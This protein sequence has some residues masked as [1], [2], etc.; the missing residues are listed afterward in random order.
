MVAPADAAAQTKPVTVTITQIEQIGDDFDFTSLGDF[1]AHVTID[2]TTLSTFD[3]R[4][5]FDS[6]FIVPSGPLIPNPAWVLTKQVP[7]TADTVAIRI[8]LFD[9]DLLT[10]AEEANLNPGSG[11]DLNLVVD[12]ATG[13]WSGDVN[14]PRAASPED[15]T[16]AAR[17]PRSASTSASFPTAAMRT[18]TGCSTAGS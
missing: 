3:D 8:E 16:W 17:T 4:F 11:N 12:L 13:R 15:T 5:S 1:Y 6:G 18:A 2:G 7:F 14:W 10:G 9:D